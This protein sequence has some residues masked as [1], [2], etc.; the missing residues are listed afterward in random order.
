M[1]VAMELQTELSSLKGGPGTAMTMDD[2]F[3]FLLGDLDGDEAFNP[4]GGCDDDDFPDVGTAR[5]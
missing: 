3:F 2:L 1:E 5:V 4:F